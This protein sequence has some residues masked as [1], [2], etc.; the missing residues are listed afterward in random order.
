[1]PGKLEYR[2][3]DPKEDRGR[4]RKKGDADDLVGKGNGMEWKRVQSYS[5]KLLYEIQSS[6]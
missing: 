1:L 5:W 3:G 4:L 2:E 6:L